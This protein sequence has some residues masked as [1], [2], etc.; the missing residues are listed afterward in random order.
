A[1]V[2]WGRNRLNIFARGTDGHLYEKKWNGGWSGW[3]DLGGGVAADPAAVVQEG[4]RI[5]L[6]VLLTSGNISYRYSIGDAWSDWQ[7]MGGAGLF[8]QAPTL[9]AWNGNWVSVFGVR[10]DGTVAY[11]WWDG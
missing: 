7:D 5:S 9:L 11:K 10:V 2:A 1:V 3:N 6:A 8:K 4:R